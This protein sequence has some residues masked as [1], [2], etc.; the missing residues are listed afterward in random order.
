M[1]R[2]RGLLTPVSMSDPEAAW[3][4]AY[5]HPTA[6]DTD[7][8]PQSMVELFEA[9][10]AARGEAPLIEFMGRSYSYAETWV[11]ANRVACGLK[12]LGYGPGDRIGLFLRK[13]PAD[14][15]SIAN[16]CAVEA[17]VRRVRYVTKRFEV[18]GIA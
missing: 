7:F 18:S 13:D 6:W 16:V 14:D 3:R 4:S 11:G 15:R 1:R 5:R 10:A 2:A 8:P 17:V 9:A 12:A